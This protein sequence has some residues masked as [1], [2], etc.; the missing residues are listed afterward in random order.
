VFCY[1]EKEPFPLSRLEQRLKISLILSLFLLSSAMAAEQPE[2]V[3]IDPA[4]IYA[5]A[6]IKAATLQTEI[7]FAWPKKS[8]WTLAQITEQT[9]QAAA[10][11]LQCGLVFSKIQLLRTFPIAEGIP[12]Y[13]EEPMSVTGIAAQTA[14][15]PHPLV[16]LVNRFS[17]TNDQQT[18]F[19]RAPFTT[20]TLKYPT[21]S[22]YTVWYPIAVSDSAYQSDRPR[23]TSILA[24]EFTHV[25]TLDG[26]HNDDHPP[27]LMTIAQ[28][29]ANTMTK[30]I[31]DEIAKSK[32]VHP[33]PKAM[34]TSYKA[35]NPV[36]PPRPGL[37]PG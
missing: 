21:S 16:H 33:A 28:H 29:R 18:A 36:A 17:D 37:P 24:H 10:V 34:A 19:S 25:L 3:F 22:Y 32:W 6:E 14:E 12:R 7:N 20:G 4:S 27:N 13:T 9:Q 5:P 8:A 30:E 2:I 23:I 15:L 31:C 1:Y 11:F 26:D 35:P